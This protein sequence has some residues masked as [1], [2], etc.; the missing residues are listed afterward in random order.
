M[1]SFLNL[2]RHAHFMRSYAT[3]SEHP[4]RRRPPASSGRPELSPGSPDSPADTS[5]PGSTSKP[6]PCKA[7]KTLSLLPPQPAPPSSD[8]A[9]GPKACRTSLRKVC[10]EPPWGCGGRTRSSGEPLQLLGER[11][12]PGMG[13]HTSPVRTQHT[14][15]AKLEDPRHRPGLHV[16]GSKASA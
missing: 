6:T 10:W 3:Q 5:P 12:A 1:R 4:S 2:A 13:R 14:D 11:A 16:D 8:G 7:P 15:G 9:T